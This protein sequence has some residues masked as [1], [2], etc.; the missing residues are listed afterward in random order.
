MP[1]I[2]VSVIPSKSPNATS[3]S[4]GSTQSSGGPDS[5]AAMMI[6]AVSRTRTRSLA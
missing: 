4:A 3:R 5:L 2:S 1:R 6:S